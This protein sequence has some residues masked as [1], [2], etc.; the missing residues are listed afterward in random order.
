MRTA[1]AALFVTAFGVALAAPIPKPK[2]DLKPA[3]DEQRK[4]VQNNLKQIG[5]ALLNYESAYGHL[6]GDVIDAKTKK[7]LLSWRVQL[8]PFFEE[9]DLYRQFKLDEPWDSENN[10]KLIE[11]LPKVF[12]PTRAKAKPGET[13]YR[14]FAGKGE[15][16]GLFAPGKPARIVEFTDGLSHTIGI[17]DAGEP[18]VWT[19][20]DSDLPVDPKGELPKLG[21][22]I[23]EDFYCVMMDGSVKTVKR[24]F[25]IAAMRAAISRAGGEVI[26][27]KDLFAGNDE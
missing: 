4:E 17:I 7:P 23:D 2:D 20:P 24:N 18:V 5:L 6:P 3:T 13:F 25:K 21:G 11:K 26:D 12:A 27:D 22:M 1:S 9:D 15:S 8:L 10:K 19:K 14:G 16:A